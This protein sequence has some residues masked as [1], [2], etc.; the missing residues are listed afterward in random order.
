MK[1][2]NPTHFMDSVDAL[3]LLTEALRLLRLKKEASLEFLD[4]LREQ[5]LRHRRALRNVIG[6]ESL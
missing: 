1:K 6:A 2:R 4:K 5:I 3:D